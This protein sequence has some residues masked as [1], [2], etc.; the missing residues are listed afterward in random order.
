MSEG[1]RW[2][3]LECITTHP[4]LPPLAKHLQ[5]SGSCPPWTCKSNSSQKVLNGINDSG[6]HAVQIS[7]HWPLV[8]SSSVTCRFWAG[9]VMLEKWAAAYNGYQYHPVEAG[10]R[11]RG[12]SD[13]IG[14]C[15]IFVTLEGHMWNK[16]CAPY[17]LLLFQVNHCRHLPLAASTKSALTHPKGRAPLFA[18]GVCLGQGVLSWKE[19]F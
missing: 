14:W 10:T 7:C 3:A 18:S 19:A 17:L 2:S 9:I 5:I 15:L 12:Y 4:Q 1:F 13:L 6:L 8:S 11:N 16:G